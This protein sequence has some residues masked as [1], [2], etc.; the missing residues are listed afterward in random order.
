VTSNG[1]PLYTFAEDRPGDAKGDGFIDV[2]AGRHFVW[3]AVAAS[4][5]TPPASHSTSGQSG[6]GYTGGGY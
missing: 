6:G 2:F 1:R 3:H 5:H 4:R